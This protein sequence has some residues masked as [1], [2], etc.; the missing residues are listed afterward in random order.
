[1]AGGAAAVASLVRD[2]PQQPGAHRLPGAEAAERA[3]GLD[4]R[5]LGG[6][7]GVGCVAGDDV[8]HSECDLLMRADELLVGARVAALRAQHELPLLVWTALHTATTPRA[9]QEFQPR[10]PFGHGEARRYQPRRTR[11][12][13]RG[14]GARVV[15]APLRAR[16]P[17]PGP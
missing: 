4:Q 6:I 15:R 3:P 7:L 2:D 11:G 10:L 16:S 8:G 5:L 12:G 13:R 1:P 17:R 9:A 14:R